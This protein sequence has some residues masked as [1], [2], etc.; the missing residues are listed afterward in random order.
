MR[1]TLTI[2]S[3]LVAFFILSSTSCEDEPYVQI[4]EIET[5]IFNEIKAHRL[6]NIPNDNLV[7]QFVI[8]KEAQLYSAA[9]AFGTQ[10][11]STSGIEPHWTTVH[12][13]IG[14]TNDLTLVQSTVSSSSAF[15][16]VQAWKDNPATDSLLLLDYTQCGAG[17]EINNGMA[18]VTVMM[19][20]YE[21]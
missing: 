7:H 10:D 21:E 12:S 4:K 18:Y 1:R 11:V 5:R 17:V 16:I 3:A 8:V 20:L 2:L 14:G 9:M 6:A 15:D 19:M 13:K